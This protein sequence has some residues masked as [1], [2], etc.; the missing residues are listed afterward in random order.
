MTATS[1]LSWKN[2]RVL[3]TLFVIFLAGSIVG[4]FTMRCV[5]HGLWHK[6]EPY[7]QEGGKKVALDRLSRELDLSSSQEKELEVILDDFVMMV[8]TLQAQMDEVRATGKVKVMRILN[9]EQK[10]KFE[11]MMGELQARRTDR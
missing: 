2:P 4:A 10:K 7:W 9:E 5:V 8:Q 3:V 11:K 6:P 1:R